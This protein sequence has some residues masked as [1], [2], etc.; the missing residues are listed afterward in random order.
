MR[1]RLLREGDREG[2]AARK[3]PTVKACLNTPAAAAAETL[4]KV[5]IL[6]I[7]KEEEGLSFLLPCG[8]DVYFLH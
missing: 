6:T 2:M 1:R 8:T 4:C 7:E 5:P 3:T